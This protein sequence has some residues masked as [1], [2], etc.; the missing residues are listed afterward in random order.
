MD[1]ET[2]CD[3]QPMLLELELQAQ[4]AAKN[5]PAWT[6]IKKRLVR[7]VG[8]DAAADD[9]AMRSREA[10]EAAYDHL[11]A[12]FESDRQTFTLQRKVG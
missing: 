12:I 3:R 6:E 11:L 2:L 10:F 8:W 5:W 7:L 4:A 1:W 9:P